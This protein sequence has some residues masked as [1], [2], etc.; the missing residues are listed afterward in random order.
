[1]MHGFGELKVD[2]LCRGIRLGVNIDRGRKGGAGPAGGRYIVLPS[3]RCVNAAMWGRFVEKSPYILVEEDEKFYVIREGGEKISEVSLVPYPQFYRKYTSYGTPMWKVALLHGVDCL[4]TTVFQ[5]CVYWDRDLGCKFCGIEL[6]LKSGR[7]ILFKK[8]KEFREVVDAAV[9]EKVCKHITLTTGTPGTPDKGAKLL[10][11]TVR[12]VKSYH[13]VPIHVQLEPPND[14]RY[15]E[16]LIDAGA[17]TIGVHIETFDEKVFHEICPGKGRTRMK[18]FYQTWEKCI[19]LFGECQVS[20][21]IIVGLGESVES[22]IKGSEK[23]AEIGVIPYIVPLRPIIGTPLGN[24]FP[25]S[26]E[27]LTCI[28]RE[29]AQILRDYGVDPRKNVAGCVRCGACSALTEAYEG[30]L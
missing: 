16:E 21:Y 6:S 24:K 30:K 3:G 7:T 1:M 10:A 18:K 29:V 23:V 9:E 5:K 25:P 13:K 4:A 2:L 26:P 17:D 22:I 14:I 8:P 27:T 15:I 20:T 12:E 28:Y 11:E 19:E